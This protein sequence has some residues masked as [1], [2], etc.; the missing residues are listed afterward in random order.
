MKA[1]TPP[2]LQRGTRPEEIEV[3]SRWDSYSRD[4]LVKRLDDVLEQV[5][6]AMRS[7]ARFEV[8]QESIPYSDGERSE[9]RCTYQ[10]PET[11]KELAD[12]QAQSDLAF[13][14]QQERDKAEFER[15]KKEFGQ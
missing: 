15:L 1:K 14:R 10:R 11:D 12:R 4:E 7:T 5:P 3:C 8:V 9:L 13:Q 2:V 6:E